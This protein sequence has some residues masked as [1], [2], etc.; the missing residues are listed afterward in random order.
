VAQDIFSTAQAEVALL[1]K[2]RWR[3]VINQYVRILE[4][5][6]YDFPSFVGSQASDYPAFTRIA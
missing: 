5:R 6:A 4:Q 2:L 3:D 1:R